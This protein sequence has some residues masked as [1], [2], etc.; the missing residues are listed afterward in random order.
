MRVMRPLRTT[1]PIGTAVAVTRPHAHAD[2]GL[3]SRHVT[4]CRCGAIQVAPSLDWLEPPPE[5]VE[6]R[7]R[8]T[9][10]PLLDREE[11]C[12]ACRPSPGR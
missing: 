11:L 12:A 7:R 1:D 9:P 10:L 6:Q 2:S 5:P 4:V 3:G 8:T